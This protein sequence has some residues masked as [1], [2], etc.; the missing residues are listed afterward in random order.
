MSDTTQACPHC[1]SRLKKWLVPDDAS[2]SEEFFFVCFNDDCSYYTDGWGWMKEQYNQEASYRYMINPTTGA[3]S[4]LPVWS[5]TATR[6]MIVEDA[7]G[8]TA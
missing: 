8:G 3:S 5:D 2:W 6:E 4:P 1:G 7:E